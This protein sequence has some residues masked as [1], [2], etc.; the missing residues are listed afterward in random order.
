MVGL[1]EVLM[2]DCW[3]PLWF[4]EKFSIIFDISTPSVVWYFSN[5]NAHSFKKFLQRKEWE[6]T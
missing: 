5:L 6:S 3:F 4:S 2:W 1:F